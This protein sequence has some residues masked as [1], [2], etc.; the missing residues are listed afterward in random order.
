MSFELTG[1]DEFE[2]G[3][4][5]LA[6]RAEALDGEHEVTFEDLFVEDFMASCTQ[7]SSIDELFEKSPFVV[8]S[9]EDFE[10]I[11]DDELDT[12]ISEVTQFESWEDMLS[13]AGAQYAARQ[14]GF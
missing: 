7:F 8:N 14:L 9:P 10:A 3:L 1:L 2:K 5:D 13:E 12:Y 4:Q 11:P 6:D